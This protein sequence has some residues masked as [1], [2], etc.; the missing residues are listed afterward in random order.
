MV[1]DKLTYALKAYTS[2]Y[3]LSPSLDPETKGYLLIADR[4][5][6][7]PT[8]HPNAWGRDKG[9]GFSRGAPPVW[10]HW[11]P[12]RVQAM[13]LA[14]DTIYVCGPPDKLKDGDPM[15]SFEGR[16]G[17]ELWALDAKTGK[18]LEKRTLTEAPAF[19]GLI[20]AEGRLLM[21]TRDGSVI[22]MGKK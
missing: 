16:M 17:S 12:V 7:D 6:N 3:P 9:M 21:S 13:V 15:A 18:I 1:G 10:H 11:L 20:A 4:N 8:M 5:E 2:R 22:C 19:D 14:G